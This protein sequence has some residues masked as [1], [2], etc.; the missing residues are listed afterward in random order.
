MR[1]SASAYRLSACPG[2]SATAARSRAAAPRA[3]PFLSSAMPDRSVAKRFRGST[4]S[5]ASKRASAPAWSPARRRDSASINASR[6]GMRSLGSARPAG[7]G[8]AGGAPPTYPSARRL[9]ITA[10]SS[11]RAAR[12]ADWRSKRSSSDSSTARRD[13]SDR[14][15]SASSPG[16]RARSYSSGRGARTYFQPPWR[17]AAR[18]DQPYVVHGCC[19]S[20]N[21][22]SGGR[23]RPASSGARLTPSV[24]GRAGSPARSSR[25]GARSTRRTGARLSRGAT[26]PGQWITAGTRTVVS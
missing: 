25:V 12:A 8:P 3:S 2:S 22:G 16:S 17:T 23:G 20:T 9:S 26:W 5:T 10:G 4:A 13:G 19:D 6:C 15:R 7:G 21:A 18:G 14:E 11:A 24:S 1:A